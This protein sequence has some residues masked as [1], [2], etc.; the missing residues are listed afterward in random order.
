MVRKN[1]KTIKDHHGQR[2]TCININ[3]NK[4]RDTIIISKGKN[5]GIPTYR[6]DCPDCHKANIGYVDKRTGK[7]SV[8]A[9]GVIRVKKNHC[10]NRFGTSKKCEGIECRTEHNVDGT[11]SSPLLHIDEIDGNHD[12]NIPENTQTLCGQCHTEKTKLNGDYT[13]KGGNEFIG[14]N[15]DEKQSVLSPVFNPIE[16]E[17]FS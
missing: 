8:Y 7:K 16:H 10:E 6:S 4:P 9:K 5:P 2:G 15:K 13:S 17:F 12:N 1:R 14:H 11:L 3:C